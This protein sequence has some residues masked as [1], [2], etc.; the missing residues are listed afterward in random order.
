M[1]RLLVKEDPRGYPDFVELLQ[2]FEE[3]LR[4]HVEKRHECLGTIRSVK[5]HIKMFGEPSGN[6]SVH[7]AGYLVCFENTFIGNERI[8]DPVFAVVGRAAQQR[9][10]LR[11]GD[12]LEFEAI[13]TVDEGRLRLDQWRKIDFR[14]RAENEM[15]WNDSKSVVARSTGTMLKHQAEKCIAC[16]QGMLVDVVRREYGKDRLLHRIFCLQGMASASACTYDAGSEL[17]TNSCSNRT[18]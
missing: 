11:R 5:P 15:V 6:P 10:Q 1:T 3:W 9:L 14:V 4:D 2:D 16:D 17:Y 13:L 12:E 7:L 8:D 18:L